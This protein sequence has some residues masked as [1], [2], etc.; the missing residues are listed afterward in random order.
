MDGLEDIFKQSN[1]DNLVAN[2][3]NLYLRMEIGVIGT[4]QHL[5]AFARKQP[6]LLDYWAWFEGPTEWSWL[7]SDSDYF[8]CGDGGGAWMVMCRGICDDEH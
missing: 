4:I 8:S 3:L 6:N 2:K 5:F 7:V 1:Y